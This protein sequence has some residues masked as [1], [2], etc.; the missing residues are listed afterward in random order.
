MMEERPG[1]DLLIHPEC[2]C[3]S[4]CMYA[5]SQ[6]AAL[7]ST[8]HVLSTEGMVRHAAGSAR[9]RLRGRHRDRHPPPTAQGGPDKRFYAMSERAVCRY[10]K[11]ITLPKVRDSLRDLRYQVTVARRGRRAR[12]AGDR[13]DGGDRLSSGPPTLVLV[14]TELEARLLAIDHTPL[15]ICGFGLVQAAVGALDAI[16]RVRPGRVLLA[17]CAGSYDAVRAP[18]GSARALGAVRCH[19]IGAGGRSAAEL[20]FA[21]S[22]QL[23]LDNGAGLALSVAEA[24]GSPPR[25]RSG[26]SSTRRRCS[27]RWRD[28]LLPSR[29]S[30]AGIG[31]SI[32]RGV[33]N[34]AGDRDRAEWRMD[35]ALAAA[36]TLVGTM[37]ER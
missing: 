1:T 5:A 6:D 21:A 15:A 20:G 9:A 29:Q 23:A 36:R 16:H 22:D 10:M 25:R 32:V 18:V 17:G 31:C 4:Q 33:S 24:S 27:R 3:A 34:L 14:P 13:A 2:G 28:M 12:P 26:R 7:A 8:T 19:G 35:E 11:Q 37:L 30:W